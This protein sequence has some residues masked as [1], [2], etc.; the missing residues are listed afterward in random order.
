M[1][2][3]VRLLSRPPFAPFLVGCLLIYVDD[4]IL[5][6]S[7]PVLLQHIVDSLHKE[8]DISHLGVLNYFFGICVV[9][10]PIK[11]FLSQ[12]KYALQLLEHAHM[13]NCNPSRTPVDT[14]SKLGLDGVP[15][16]DHTIYRSLAGG[17]S[18]LPLLTQICPMHVSRFVSIC[19]I[20]WSR[21]LLLT[22]VSCPM[23][24]APWSL[25]FT[26]MLSLLHLELG[27]LMLIG[28]VAIILVGLLPVI[29]TLY[30]KLGYW[31][32]VPVQDPI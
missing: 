2:C 29:Q 25:V 1:R 31:T 18:I 11:L 13:V 9:R 10:H 15:V 27:T 23:F 16:Q 22:N 21:T 17:S 19:M 5:T 6:A 12:K 20:Q 4:I 14:D 30:S 3:L 26:Y 32:A 7:S 8:F 24:R 28:Q